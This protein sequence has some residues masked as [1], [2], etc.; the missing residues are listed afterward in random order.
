MEE[1]KKFYWIKLR[2]DF[3]NQDEIDFLMSQENGSQ[4]VVLYQML[5][6]QTA[7]Q[8]G[9]FAKQIGEVLVPY[10]VKKIVRD[11]KFFDFDTVAIALELFKRIGLI[12]VQENEM[13]KIA[14]IE[15]M[16]GSESA[17]KEAIKKRKQ[18]AKRKS[19]QNNGDGEGD[20]DGTTEGT[21]CPQESGTKCPTEYRDKSLEY[22]VQS[23]DID[24]SLRNNYSSSGSNNIQ[25]PNL[26]PAA[27]A[28][29]KTLEECGFQINQY[30][31]S[32]ILSLIDDFGDI[33][34]TEAIRRAS[35]A[36]VRNIRYIAGILRS[37]Q[38]KGGID[39]RNPKCSTDSDKPKKSYPEALGTVV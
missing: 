30:L 25:G 2:M 9:V 5:C 21:K 24:N 29:M 36:N 19:L 11:T 31:A 26:Y 27:A 33:W 34:V 38:E 15:S 7:N 10:D 20:N 28:V 32:Q 35:D 37:W 39:E 1:G 18:R 23:T 13:L 6:L 16:V 14:N 4:Y 22:R 8:N 3:F 12:Y 17:N